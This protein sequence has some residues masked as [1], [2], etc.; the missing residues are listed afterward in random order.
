M[1]IKNGLN[2]RSFAF[3]FI[4]WIRLAGFA[5]PRFAFGA[6]P[7]S[8]STVDII[9][10]FAAVTIAST[11]LVIVIFLI[12]VLTHKNTTVTAADGGAIFAAFLSAEVTGWVLFGGDG[13]FADVA[14]VFGHFL[15]I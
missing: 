11:S 12:A 7:V 3:A 15:G 5:E 6:R 8:I 13:F 2:R 1:R 10:A 4:F 14:G 9:A